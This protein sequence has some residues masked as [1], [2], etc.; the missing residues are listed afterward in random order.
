M[1]NFFGQINLKKLQL[2]SPKAIVLQIFLFL[3][4]VFKSK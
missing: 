3:L 4:F 2:L 1:Q